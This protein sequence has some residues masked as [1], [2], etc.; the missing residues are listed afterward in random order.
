MTSRRW[1]AAAMLAVWL[2]G[3]AGAQPAAPPPSD[4]RCLAAY[5]QGQ[6]LRLKHELREARAEWLLCARE[7]CPERFRAQCLEW[8]D[9]VDKLVPSVVI[10][11]EGNPAATEVRVL[12]DGVV[13]AERLDGTPIEV[14]P[15]EHVFRFEPKGGAASEQRVLINAGQ[16]T[17]ALTIVAAPSAPPPTARATR[18]PWIFAGISAVALG[19]FAFFGATGLSRRSDLDRCDPYCKQSDIDNV[20]YRFIAA[21]VSLAISAASF[22]V[23]LYTWLRARNTNEAVHVEASGGPHAAYLGVVG[24][25]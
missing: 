20:R 16:K 4:D 18:T 2:A 1:I 9:E 22:G 15:G 3:T 24:R 5:E 23:A 11:I 25:F 17:R 7:P 14:N 12:V 10:A 13:V 6:R 21:D 8:F 19:S